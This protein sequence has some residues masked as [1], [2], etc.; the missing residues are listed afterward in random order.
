MDAWNVFNLIAGVA[1]IAGGI[2]SF[3]QA[4][5]S[6]SAATRAQEIK[7]QMIANKSTSDMSELFSSYRK[8]QRSM[9]KFGPGSVP[10]TLKGITPTNETRDVQEFYALLKQYRGL[11]GQNTPNKADTYCENLSAALEAFAQSQNERDLH[12]NGKSLYI[13][14]VDISPDIKTLMDERLEKTF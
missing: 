4:K 2:F 14:L 11:F 12:K 5:K 3:W 1:S 13:M 10:S 7:D 6:Q 9:E 8:A